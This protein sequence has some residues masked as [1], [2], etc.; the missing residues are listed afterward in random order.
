MQNALVLKN[1]SLLSF[2][3]G[4][5]S[6]LLANGRSGVVSLSS[7]FQKFLQQRFLQQHKSPSSS[8]LIQHSS[9]FMQQQQQRHRI[10]IAILSTYFKIAQIG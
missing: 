4:I 3:K 5:A 2:F 7:P 10:E 9:L 6:F 8:Q 1:L